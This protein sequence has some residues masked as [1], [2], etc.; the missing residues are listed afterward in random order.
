[1]NKDKEIYQA[2]ANRENIRDRIRRINPRAL[3][4]IDEIDRQ[5]IKAGYRGAFVDITEDMTAEETEMALFEGFLK[6][7][8]SVEEASR[9]AKEWAGL[10]M[11]IEQLRR[12]RIVGS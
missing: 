6:E 7:G 10:H 4:L 1:M 9:K 2:M 8:Y 3:E 12:D 11:K 5:A